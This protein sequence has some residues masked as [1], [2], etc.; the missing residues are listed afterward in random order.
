MKPKNKTKQDK[1]KK[2]DQNTTQRLQDLQTAYE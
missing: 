2:P 1:T